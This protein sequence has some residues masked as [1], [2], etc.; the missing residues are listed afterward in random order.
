MPLYLTATECHHEGAHRKGGQLPRAG[1]AD[2]DMDGNRRTPLVLAQSRDAA[3]RVRLAVVGAV[4]LATADQFGAELMNVLHEPGVTGVD[5]DFGRLDLIDSIGVNTLVMGLRV[6]HLRKI[7][8]RV[9]NAR[10]SVLAHLRLLGLDELLMPE[11]G[12]RTSGNT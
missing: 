2:H 11:S 4:D 5:L 12:S 8:Y 9:V 7:D 3:R 6:A 10:G 1:T